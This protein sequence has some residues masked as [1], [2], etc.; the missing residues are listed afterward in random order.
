MSGFR[1][2]PSVDLSG[3]QNHKIRSRPNELHAR[4][5]VGRARELRRGYEWEFDCRKT[6]AVVHRI[7]YE[8]LIVAR[9]YLGYQNFP[10]RV[11][12]SH[13]GV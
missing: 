6:M 8:C 5:G 11:R 13:T 10:I 4:A 3:R 12:H 1:F 2:W 7:K 9:V